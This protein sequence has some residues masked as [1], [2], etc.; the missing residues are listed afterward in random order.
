MQKQKKILVCPLNWGI[1]HAT[2]CVPVINELLR[3]GNNVVIAADG[4]PL[5]FLRKEFPGLE[6]ITFKGYSIIYPKKGSM[7]WKM[8]LSV[9]KILRGIRE[10]HK[11]LKQIIRNHHIDTVISDNRYGL[12][13]NDVKTIFITHQVMVKMPV[14]VKFLEPVLSYF[15]RKQIK[16]FDECWIPDFALGDT[17]SGDLSHKY[18]LKGNVQFVGPLSRFRDYEIRDDETREIFD[19]FVI[20]SGP[21]PQRTKLEEIIFSQLKKSLLKAVIVRGIT[22]KDESYDINERVKVF[23]HL[24]TQE[25]FK[26]FMACKTVICRPGYSSI[27]DLV[28]LGKKAIFI[29]TPGQTEQEYLAKYLMKKKM[30][31]SVKQNQFLLEEALLESEN[32]KGLPY[33]FT[34]QRVTMLSCV[35]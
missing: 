20:I 14:Y 32:I 6:F 17:L 24:S 30:F 27:M 3:K 33:A 11:E 34:E 31:Y 21:E 23:S 15:I 35:Q 28:T 18:T 7:I 4:R 8:L 9:P 13:N 25:M 12:W 29:P 10:E 26:Y 5:A 22:E 1:G 2:R 19:V 16:K